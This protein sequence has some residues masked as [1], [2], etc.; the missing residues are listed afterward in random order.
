MGSFCNGEIYSNPTPIKLHS[1][2]TLLGLKPITTQLKVD[3][4]V[5]KSQLYKIL[6]CISL[7]YP[8]Y[9]LGVLKVFKVDKG[10]S[11]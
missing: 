2:S 11:S 4:L 9:L 10:K 8:S 5:V 6:K 1:V 3:F 7:S